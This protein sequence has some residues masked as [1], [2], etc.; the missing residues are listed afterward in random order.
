[1]SAGQ[2]TSDELIA[3]QVRSGHRAHSEPTINNAWPIVV[4]SSE[5]EIDESHKALSSP[6]SSSGK[7]VYFALIVSVL[8]ATFGVTWII[9]NALVLPFDLASVGGSI[10]NL[11]LNSKAVSSS[12]G[13]SSNSSQDGMLEGQKGD[14]LQ[15]HDTVV[16]DAGRDAIAGALQSPNLSTAVHTTSIREQT[17]HRQASVGDLRTPTKTHSHA[18]NKTKQQLRA[19]G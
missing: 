1:M 3:T 6:A 8:V 13:Q 17:F 11:H 10:G 7:T 19:G 18:G 5:I 9:L 2:L 14:R 16:R 4:R 12:L 15:I